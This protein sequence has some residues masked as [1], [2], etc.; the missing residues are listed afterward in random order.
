MM[1]L[2]ILGAFRYLHRFATAGAT[3]PGSAR[4]L[5][6]LGLRDSR[7]FRRLLHLGVI[8][9]SSTGYYAEYYLDP[10]KAAEFRNRRRTAILFVLL[11]A[12]GIVISVLLI[13]SANAPLHP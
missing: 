12:A 1:Y 3:R 6:E 10:T 9:E 11:G 2:L 4:T 5:R 13:V 7:T 8:V